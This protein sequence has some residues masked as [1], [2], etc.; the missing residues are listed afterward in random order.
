MP[1]RRFFPL[2]SVEEQ[3]ACFVDGGTRLP[4]IGLIQRTVPQRES[5]VPTG[6]GA[7]CIGE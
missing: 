7:L 3:A 6:S 2:W 1:S 4:L 5:S